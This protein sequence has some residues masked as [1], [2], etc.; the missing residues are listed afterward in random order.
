[1]PLNSVQSIKQYE[2]SQGAKSI[3]SRCHTLTSTICFA[4]LSGI[5]GLSSRGAAGVRGVVRECSHYVKLDTSLPCTAHFVSASS[6]AFPLPSTLQYLS[7][8]AN[9]R[10]F[11]LVLRYR[12]FQHSQKCFEE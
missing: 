1:M 9:D 5:A 3:S 11:D 2:N 4:F 6:L 10:I 7:A 12:Q 8:C